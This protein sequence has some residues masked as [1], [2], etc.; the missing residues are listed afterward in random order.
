[1]ATERKSFEQLNN[2]LDH[3]KVW[4]G[5]TI[6]HKKS[7]NN[8]VIN[9]VQYKEADMTVEFS[10]HPEG[11]ANLSFSRPIGELTDGRYSFSQR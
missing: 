10:Y 3:Y 7:D 8:Y 11:W 5:K 6:H 9:S 2:D 1:M 4:I